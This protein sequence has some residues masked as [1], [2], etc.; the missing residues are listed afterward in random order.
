MIE[1]MDI[2][3][4]FKVG[5]LEISVVDI[6][7]II[8]FGT[9]MYMVYRLL[10]GGLAYNIL[11]GLFLIYLMWRITAGL[12]M[13]LM[14]NVLNQFVGV[15]VLLVVIIF[16]P[17][18]RR[19]LLFIGKGSGIGKDKFWRRFL[20]KEFGDTE[21]LASRVKQ[22]K[23]AVQNMSKT[24]TGAIIVFADSSDKQVFLKNCVKVEA[25]ISQRLL[26][27]I[28]EKNA[29]LHDGAVVILDHQIFSAATVLP[30]SE[31]NKLPAHLGLRHRAAVG[32]TEMIE[33][34]VIIVSEETGFISVAI[35][36]NISTNVNEEALQDAIEQGFAID[37]D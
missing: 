23:S 14:A 12:G 5:F 4:G 9:L 16:Q 34:V 20:S 17:E 7:D 10:R 13:T 27:S 6:L 32:I 33:S 35:N 24:K 1:V 8:L 36:G 18:L 37:L 3:L 21:L 26:E 22:V 30:V 11:I 15:G 2:I 28:F 19:F 29:P 25:T 31:N